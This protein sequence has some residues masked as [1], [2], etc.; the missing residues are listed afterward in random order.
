MM[1]TT[2]GKLVVMMVFGLLAAGVCGLLHAL[3]VRHMGSRR[4]Q[5]A[6]FLHHG[7]LAGCVVFVLAALTFAFKGQ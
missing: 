1:Q 3:T 7:F 5:E 6:E 2:D 4:W